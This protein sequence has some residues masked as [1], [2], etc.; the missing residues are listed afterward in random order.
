MQKKMRVNLMSCVLSAVLLLGLGG[1]SNL[2]SEDQNL[3][4]QDQSECVYKPLD[5]VASEL[6]RAKGQPNE[7]ATPTTIKDVI[8]NKVLKHFIDENGRTWFVSGNS[9]TINGTCYDQG[10]EMYIHGVTMEYT[11]DQLNVTAY[12]NNS[13][14]MVTVG[15]EPNQTTVIARIDWSVGA[16]NLNL[17]DQSNK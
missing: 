15:V 16:S 7:Y 17:I 12:P 2:P 4:S 1:C 8:E 5:F 11:A 3:T 14:Y 13:Y 9:G 6:N 10:T